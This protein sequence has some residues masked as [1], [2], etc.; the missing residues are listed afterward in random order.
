L[1]FRERERPVAMRWIDLVLL[2]EVLGD[3]DEFFRS[4]AHFPVVWAELRAFGSGPE[5]PDAGALLDAVCLHA[6]RL[7]ELIGRGDD[8]TR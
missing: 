8:V 7:R 5:R 4:P 6:A 1:W 2:A 3:V